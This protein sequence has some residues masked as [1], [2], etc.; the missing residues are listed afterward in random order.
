MSKSI[1]AALWSGLVFPGAGHLFLKFNGR[2]IGLIAVSAICLFI[3]VSNAAEQAMA[4]LAKIEADGGMV[5]SSRVLALASQGSVSADT[6]SLSIAM[7]VLIVCWIVGV[8]DA[9]RLGKR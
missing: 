2:G 1:K 4:V 9:Y 3:I 5:D 6:Q 8:A 7:M